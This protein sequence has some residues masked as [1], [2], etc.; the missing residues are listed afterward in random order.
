MIAEV[1]TNLI[2]EIVEVYRWEQD[3]SRDDC[4]Y[5][6]RLHGRGHVRAVYVADKELMVLVEH[7]LGIQSVAWTDQAQDGG[8]EAYALHNRSRDF[9]V[10]I[11]VVQRCAHCYSWDQKA[12]LSHIQ[13]GD[14]G[15]WDWVHK[16]GEG[17]KKVGHDG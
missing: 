15:A 2:G 6:Y 16:D 9:S 14:A 12:L 17:C 4:H 11:R 7:D 5:H 8:F 13:A 1:V 3:H 10:R